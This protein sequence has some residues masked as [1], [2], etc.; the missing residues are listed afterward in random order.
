MG[1]SERSVI[2]EPDIRNLRAFVAEGI[3]DAEAGR[4]SAADEVYVRV[5]ARIDELTGQKKNG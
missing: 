5:L 1:T 4:L 2:K 3:A